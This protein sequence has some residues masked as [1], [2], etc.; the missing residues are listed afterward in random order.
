MC[1][2]DRSR[3]DYTG[4]RESILK[5]GSEKFSINDHLV[6]VAV[7]ISLFIWI[8][9]SIIDTNYHKETHLI[10]ELFFPYLPHLWPRLLFVSAIIAFGI[11]SQHMVKRSR[12]AEDALRESETRYRNF[13]EILKDIV[14][15][16][17]TE[18]RFTYL[19]PQI[20][21]VTGYRI[22]ELLG[23]RFTDILS[24]S[25][26][27][28]TL[29]KFT[30]AMA[31]ENIPIYE[32]DML[33]KAG[34]PV[35]MELNVRTIRDDEG[36]PIG[37]IGVA[38]DITGRKKVEQALKESE[39]KF[40]VLAESSPT[41]IMLYQDNVWIYAN[42]AA[43]KI[44]GY[45]ENEL[46]KMHF[47]DIVHPDYR[48]L[49]QQRGESR[50]KGL[51]TEQRY[52]FKILTKQGI[53]TWVDLSGAQTMFEGRPAGIISV[54]D[55][56]DK[57]LAEQ[58]IRE[59]EEKY[60]TILESIEEGYFELDLKGNFTF[61][62]DSLCRIFACPKDQMS[63]RNYQTFIRDENRRKIRRIALNVYKTGK[64]QKIINCDIIRGDAKN[65]SLE[66]SLSLLRDASD[67]PAGFRGIAR[68]NTEKKRL[69][70][71]LLQ[72]QKMEAIGTLAG[73]IAHDFNNLLMA[74]QGNTSLIKMDLASESPHIK[75]L[76]HIERCV[77]SGSE[78]T[79]Q[80]LGFARGGKYEVRPVDLNELIRKSSDMFGNTKKEIQIHT[81]LNKDLW[82]VEADH[83]QIEQVMLNLYV[84][85]WQAM[86]AGGEL[87]LETSNVSLDEQY[88]R[89]YEANPGRYVKVSV[90]DTGKGISR[91]VLQRIFDPFFTTKDKS[92]GSGLGLASAYGI[93]RNHGGIINVYSEEGKGT[94]F[95]IYLP[96]SDR[97]IVKEDSVIPQTLTG[98]ETV[99][100]IDDEEMII[101][102]GTEILKKLGYTVYTAESGEQALKIYAEKNDAIDIVILDMIMPGISG[103]ETYEGLREIN[104]DVKVLLSSG[105]SL[106]GHSEKILEKGCNGFI[107]KPF[108]ITDLSIKIREVLN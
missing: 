36:T 45:S 76:E 95:S 71:Q 21:K 10:Q 44:C 62:N 43:E 12:L 80:L 24:P 32:V 91:S 87:Y 105:Y 51:A 82:N 67:N 53:E 106:N 7:V 104:N 86:P 8:A 81:K 94:T 20:E 92:R 46:K 40:R 41:A 5:R 6:A 102:I 99:L 4:L 85:A 52:E 33:S 73:G 68:D 11:F 38:R 59:S 66:I 98:N 96:A 29:N 84:N 103:A 28:T 108:N 97:H 26:Q 75:R 50:Q 57:K 27:K 55:I 39:E 60:R 35:S 3:N 18:G 89:T 93:I 49:V 56:N 54:I 100:L 13:V 70:A 58:T 2:R 19:N 83:G 9:Q 47:W 25:Y 107:Q 14:F 42:P 101:D 22:E 78:L 17:D 15:T 30:R 72:A 63:G 79:K 34:E 64:P 1:I 88:V 16:I 77:A 74:V 23:R 65:S 69:E 90:T 31:G 61:F 37:R 48:K